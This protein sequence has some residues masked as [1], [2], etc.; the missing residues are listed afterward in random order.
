[1]KLAWFLF[2]SAFPFAVFAEPLAITSGEHDGFTRLVVPNPERRNWRLVETGGATELRIDGQNE[3][4]DLKKIFARIS[5]ERLSKVEQSDDGES[6]RL[7]LGCECVV[8]SFG[9]A[10]NFIVLDIADD[11]NTKN[12][13]AVILPTVFQENRASNED[14]KVTD[15]I[16]T[17]TA[18]EI[19]ILPD[20]LEVDPVTST[21]H[22]GRQLSEHWMAAH[23]NR[24]INQE[25]LTP[26]QTS[27]LISTNL[28]GL[29]DDLS[30]VGVKI[31]TS[32]ESALP[33]SEGAQSSNPKTQP[34]NGFEVSKLFATV[35]NL[36]TFS[37]VGSLRSNLFGEFDQLNTDSVIQVAVAYLALGFGAEARQIF[38][39]A[40]QNRSEFN[41]FG[42]VS[43]LIDDDQPLADNP[44]FGQQHCDSTLALWAVLA[45]STL[46]PN[47]RS[48]A[49]LQ[50][51]THLP[52][53]LRMH[54]GPRLSSRF[55][56]SGELETA[57]M[58][59]RVIDQSETGDQA[60]FE[61]AQAVLADNTGAADEAQA[62][63]EQV[64][65]SETDAAIPALIRLV[66]NA[67]LSGKPTSPNVRELAASLAFEHQETPFSADL[68]RAAILS[69]A[70]SGD[71]D[72]ASA[73]LGKLVKT[74]A[75][76]S[77]IPTKTVHSF[78]ELLERDADDVSFLK[79]ALTYIAGAK[80]D[81]PIEL[82]T[83]LA[84]RLLELGFPELAE[85]VLTSPFSSG[86]NRE[87]RLLR[88]RLALEMG[89]P[90]RA[91]V[92]LLGMEDE[93]V[94]DLRARAM[95]I[96][97]DRI[98]AAEL[99]LAANKNV[100]AARNFWV[101]EE[102]DRISATGEN[103]YQRAAEIADVLSRKSEAMDEQPLTHAVWLI[104]SSEKMRSSVS[105]LLSLLTVGED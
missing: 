89:L 12:A 65:Q 88:A 76:T 93:E 100:D 64:A 62:G 43:M 28:S 21:Q 84:N 77:M 20:S 4:F 45:N 70:M 39:L 24:A 9:V 83:R 14:T 55:S 18:K 54:L 52:K 51:F 19:S 3:V 7:Y 101:S 27:E 80:M 82:E 73:E 32:L 50:S 17:D 63:F 97:G 6:L 10:G 81:L 31:E 66:E 42:A 102:F 22:D 78:L 94:A 53:I 48:E 92:V 56:D 79:H 96:Y 35:E 2:L 23:I 38:E 91:M 95:S 13:D 90:H 11:K 61:L 86:E 41:A 34:C 67:Y 105:E 59:L 87:R 25:L 69:L 68:H 8:S 29:A 15:P 47:T 44:F 75:S 46:P 58:I 57:G 16:T 5:R 37:E 74:S 98:P 60:Q 30:K 104:D 40:G 36:E 26:A 85:T 33:R 49:V 72:N 103:Q 1:M 99:L 71:F